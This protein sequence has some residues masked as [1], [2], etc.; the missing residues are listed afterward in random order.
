MTR[1]GEKG[2]GNGGR[3]AAPWPCYPC[4]HVDHAQD[5]QSGQLQE[6]RPS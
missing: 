6:S 3:T 2:E 5:V 4:S 1:E